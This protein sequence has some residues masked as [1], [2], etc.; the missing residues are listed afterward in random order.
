MNKVEIKI[1]DLGKVK[2]EA[3]KK[4]ESKKWREKIQEKR[5]NSEK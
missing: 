1:E 4:R 5:E 3:R 2:W